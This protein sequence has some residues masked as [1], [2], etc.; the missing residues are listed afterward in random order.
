[1][2]FGE[3]LKNARISKNLTQQEMANLLG[4]ALRTY[5]NY[6]NAQT[7]PRKR[8]I[9]V[10]MAEILQVQLNYLLTED[11][12][13]TLQAHEQYGER[14]AKQAQAMI[15]QIGQMYAGGELSSDDMD[16]VM[17]SMQKLYWDAKEENKKYAS[18]N[19]KKGKA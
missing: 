3:K 2:K 7:Y 12:V 18:R 15:S 19:S 13:F 8:E 5:T 6:E 11:E 9:Y 16:A 10:K 14:G 4:I 1:M 17:K